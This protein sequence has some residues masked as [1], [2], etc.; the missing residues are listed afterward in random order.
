MKVVRV[1]AICS[2]SHKTEVPAVVEFEVSV[3][4]TAGGKPVVVDACQDCASG[5]IRA[6]IEM[7]ERERPAQRRRPKRGEH[8]CAEHDRSYVSAAALERHM[9]RMAH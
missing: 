2:G 8:Y 6:L 3:K 7:I 5:A 9:D 1:E 4:G